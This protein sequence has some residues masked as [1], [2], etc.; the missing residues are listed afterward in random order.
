MLIN[1]IFQGPELT[2]DYTLTESAGITTIAFTGAATSVSY[3]VNNASIPRGGIIVSVGST[4]GFGYQPL[5]SAGGTATVSV[6]GTISAI[7]VGN[8]GSGYR[9]SSTYEIVVDTSFPVGIGST[10]IYL[11]NT[12]SIFSILNLLNTGFNCSIGVGTFIGS[13]SV[14]TSVGSTFVRVG[15]GVTSPYQIPSG[16][17]TIIKISNPQIGIVNVGVGTSSVGI[18]TITHV[19]YSTIISGSI[20]TSVTITNPGTGYTSTNR[21]YVIF[22]D[23]LSYSN[24]PLIYSS[25][26]SGVGTAAKINIVVGQGSSVIDFEIINTGYGYGNG[27]ILTV[28]IGGTTGIPTTGASF[29]EFKINIEKTFTDKFVGWSIGELQVLDSLDKV[30]TLIDFN[31]TG[32]VG[33]PGVAIGIKEPRKTF[34][35]KYN[36]R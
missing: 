35:Q 10:L 12:N 25:G 9:A 7:S 1:D 2:N 32:K 30:D 16:T 29:S 8:S 20:S 21:P 22:D 5:V 6:A 31:N 14:I 36:V 27:Q 13:G 18:A 17:Q 19:G 34:K 24:I 28:P 15:S 26:S 11:E 3:D 33:I 4:G 23:P